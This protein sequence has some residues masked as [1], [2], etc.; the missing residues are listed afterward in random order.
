[1]SKDLGDLKIDI[2]LNH[3]PQTDKAKDINE[4]SKKDAALF[5]N[6]L[7]YSLESTK[8]VDRPL[9]RRY[10]NSETKSNKNQTIT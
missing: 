5:E 9:K 7:S 3:L 1:M 2:K 4:E 6:Y 10:N 8:G